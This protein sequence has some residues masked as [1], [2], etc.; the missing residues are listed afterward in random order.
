M[1]IITMTA[2]IPTNTIMTIIMISNM[3]I[4]MTITIMAMSIPTIIILA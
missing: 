1:R 2:N 3:I 4:T